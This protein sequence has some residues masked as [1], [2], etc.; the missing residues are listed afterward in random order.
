MPCGHVYARGKLHKAL[1][2]GQK[3]W[4]IFRE[5]L[6]ELRSELKAEAA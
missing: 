2:I 1:A 5:T 4:P 3:S 6:D